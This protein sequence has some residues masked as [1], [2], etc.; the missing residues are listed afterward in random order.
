MLKTLKLNKK[1][2]DNLWLKQERPAGAGRSRL[3]SVYFAATT[4]KVI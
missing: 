3:Q 1:V 2:V 4:F